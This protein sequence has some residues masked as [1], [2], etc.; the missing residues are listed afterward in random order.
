MQSC[1]SYANAVYYHIFEV[2]GE[3]LVACMV[4]MKKKYPQYEIPNT[5]RKDSIDDNY[6]YDAAFYIK[7]KNII[8]YA[9]INLNP[10]IRNEKSTYIGIDTVLK[11]WNTPNAKFYSIRELPITERKEVKRIFE[12]EILTKLVV[13]Q[14]WRYK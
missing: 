2:S 6:F 13:Y 14:K 1:G 5:T 9:I 3:Q 11:E 12:T 4:E 7:E 10:N 8:I